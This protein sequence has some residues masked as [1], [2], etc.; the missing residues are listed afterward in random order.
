MTHSFY[1]QAFR[2]YNIPSFLYGLAAKCNLEIDIKKD[3]LFMIDYFVTLKGSAENIK[4]FQ[5]C[6]HET[7]D[8]INKMD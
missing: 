7:F 5:D 3:G 6:V 8:R 1:M 4:A 2:L